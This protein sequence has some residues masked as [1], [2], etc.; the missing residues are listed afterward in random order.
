[1][2]PYKLFAKIS[3]HYGTA[4]F[5]SFGAKAVFWVAED[6][7]LLSMTRGYFIEDYRRYFFD[8]IEYMMIRKTIWASLIYTFSFI[9]CAILLSLGIA[10]FY[11]EPVLRIFFFVIATLLAIVTT[12]LMLFRGGSCVVFIK[13]VTGTQK[14]VFASNYAPALRLLS[15]IQNH[16][17]PQDQDT[18]KS[19]TDSSW[20]TS[21]ESAER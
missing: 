17:A 12:F 14:Q 3:A 2:N 16:I 18:E 19:Q 8:D 15:K 13:T 6:H 20:K 21:T 9:L 7:F 4:F 10:F 1:M 5:F 11:S